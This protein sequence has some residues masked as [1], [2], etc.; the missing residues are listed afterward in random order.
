M[1]YVL[2]RISALLLQPSYN[3]LAGSLFIMFSF[4]WRHFRVMSDVTVISSYMKRLHEFCSNK[5]PRNETR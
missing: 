3:T 1:R 5:V 2:E 4:M